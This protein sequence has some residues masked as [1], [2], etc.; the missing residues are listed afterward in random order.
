MK[1]FY[2]LPGFNVKEMGSYCEYCFLLYLNIVLSWPEDGRL[3]P[4]HVAKY[5]LIV[6]IASCLDACYVLT[7]HKIYYTSVTHILCPM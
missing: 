5:N 1:N 6:I 4:K 2:N 7:V 3:R